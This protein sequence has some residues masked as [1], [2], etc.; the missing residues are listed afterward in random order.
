MR[1]AFPSIRL[2]SEPANVSRPQ[3]RNEGDREQRLID[4]W[5]RDLYDELARA[6]EFDIRLHEFACREVRRRLDLL[7]IAEFGTRCQEVAAV[8]RA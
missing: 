4:L 6:N 3:L 2:G 8:T 7:P 5:G 1:P